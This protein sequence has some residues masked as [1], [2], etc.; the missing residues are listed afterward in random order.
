MSDKVGRE[1]NVVCRQ[2]QKRFAALDERMG[3][4]KISVTDRAATEHHLQTCSRCAIEYRLF[5]LQRATLDAAATPELITPDEYFFRA[6]RARIAR[7]PERSPSRPADESWAAALLVTSR[8]LLPAMAVL[9][10]LMIG[11]TL[12]WNQPPVDTSQAAVRPRERVMFSD[13]Y[14]YPAPT[15][16]DVLETLVAVEEK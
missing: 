9:L 1:T 15:R 8:Q 14:D 7:G 11:A 16:D 6:L 4:V 2:A 3:T 5:A 10:L 13:M 12:V